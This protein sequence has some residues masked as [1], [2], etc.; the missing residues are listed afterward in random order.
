MGIERSRDP[1]RR[2]SG[3]ERPHLAL[4]HQRAALHPTVLAHSAH[5]PATG[6]DHH[7]LRGSPDLERYAIAGQKGFDADAVNAGIQPQIEG[8]IGLQA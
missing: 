8:T 6:L 2:R 3:T 7:S 5:R 1:V 4:K